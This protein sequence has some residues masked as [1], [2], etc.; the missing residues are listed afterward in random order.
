M[1]ARLAVGLT[2]LCLL[3]AAAAYYLE[4]RHYE[5][6]DDAF[7]DGA[8]VEIAAQV[9]GTTLRVAVKANQ[10]V[11]SGTLLAEIDPA[12]Y[13]ARVEA[14][15][16]DLEQNRAKLSAAQSS[17]DLARIRTASALAEA[18]AKEQAA[19]AEL[20]RAFANERAAATDA[21]RRHEDWQRYRELDPRALSE[22][23]RD[24][25][26]ANAHGAAAAAKAAH[27][28]I[29][30]ARARLAAARARVESSDTVKQQ[31]ALA[32]AEVEQAKAAIDSAEARL[33]AAS[34]DLSHTILRAPVSGYVVRV[35]ADPGEYLRPGRLLMAMVPRDL[36][37][38]ANFK[39]TQLE[40]MH[41]GQE[42]EI[43][44]DA[45]P[46]RQLHG[47]VESIQKG[48]GAHFSLFPPENA[49]GSFV[50]IVQRVPVRIAIDDVEDEDLFL[51]PGM[52]VVP[53]VRVR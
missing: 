37:I 14:A 8:L 44:V 40:D 7:I 23:Q 38:T 4:S 16:A 1:K 13:R 26:E 48:T 28:G 29:A 24:L 10:W 42:V 33:A 32:R 17:L 41:A 21:G 11:E 46:S 51:A 30:A 50:K 25:A 3:V 27:E 45:F 15:E 18:R 22:Q 49:T 5:S 43:K 53:S 31:I 34:I 9:A 39:E 35:D 36:W 19:Q 2:T 20:D 12:P 52:S 47:R 6:T